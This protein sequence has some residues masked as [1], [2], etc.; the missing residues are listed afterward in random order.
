MSACIGSFEA[1]T[2]DE[3]DTL[4]YSR[5]I[6]DTHFGDLT[7]RLPKRDEVGELE[8][9]IVTPAFTPADTSAQELEATLYAIAGYEDAVFLCP[10][11]QRY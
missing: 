6:G 10:E 7:D 2:A 4:R 9:S 5:G 8:V 11:S 1:L 3:D